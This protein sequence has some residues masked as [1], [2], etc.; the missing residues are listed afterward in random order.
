MSDPVTVVIGADTTGFRKGAQEAKDHVSSLIGSLKEF[1]S[2]AVS[3]GRS[4]RFF[5]TELAEVIPGAE[6]AK[7]AMRDL[8]KVGLSGFG[9]IG[10]IEGVIFVLKQ[11][12][13]AGAEEEKQLKEIAEEYKK[14]GTE[15]KKAY[16]QIQRSLLGLSP[17]QMQ[18]AKDV[19]A[20]I[21]ALGKVR[22]AI[23]DV[24]EGTHPVMAAGAA[25]NAIFGAD[26]GPITT[27]AEAIARLRDEEARLVEQLKELKKLRDETE[28]KTVGKQQADA[29]AALRLSEGKM[30]MDYYQKKYDDAQK[31]FTDEEKAA[32]DHLL[33]LSKA[34][35]DAAIAIQKMKDQQL[36]G[37][38][39]RNKLIEDKEDKEL[40]DRKKKVTVFANYIEHAMASSIRSVI[41]G[42]KSIAGAAIDLMKGLANAVI[43]GLLRMAEE[44]VI[45]AIVGTAAVKK[46]AI[47]STQ[48]HIAE[49]VAGAY[50]SQAF[51]PFIGP[52]LGAEAALAALAF[53]E[54]TT[55]PLLGFKTGLPLVPA[56]M[57]VM[58]HSREA[59]LTENQ[60]DDW[61]AG[62]GGGGGDI[63]LH[64]HAV[65]ADAASLRRLPEDPHFRRGMREVVR[66]GGF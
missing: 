60:A 18:W 62:R 65:Y 14:V 5:A 50:A 37:Q 36:A 8:I 13:E 54:T 55:G 41:E 49:G 46:Q 15:G 32:Q 2:E 66:N 26:V 51:I 63:H 56:D 35:Y 17:A 27:R 48:G 10:A 59:I 21:E 33:R 61:R 9:M 30:W 3:T 23:K 28:E 39:Q 40:E 42:T 38:L 29:D 47:S 64:V 53:L 58:V 6:G 20:T 1:K 57:P 43:D 19:E 16:E 31:A 7:N 22:V 45:G 12:K 24:E 4:A 11:L 34:E 44:A 25:L 52:E